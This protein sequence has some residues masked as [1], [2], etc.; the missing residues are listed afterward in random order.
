MSEAENKGALWQSF[1]E[2]GRHI[3]RLAVRWLIALTAFVLIYAM[4]INTVITPSRHTVNVGDVAAED[5]YAPRTAEDTVKTNA[6]RE[7]ARE[8]V[9][10]SYLEDAAITQKVLANLETCF[11]QM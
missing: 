8:A 6:A 4:M 10:I 1:S 2:K 3:L 9:G 11:D 7:A 5:I